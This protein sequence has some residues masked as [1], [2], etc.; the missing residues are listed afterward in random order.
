MTTT[1]AQAVDV[2]TELDENAGVTLPLSSSLSNDDR[3]KMWKL[4]S[5]LLAFGNTEKANELSRALLAS[6]PPMNNMAS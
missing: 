1:E 2:V 4:H 6:L 5:L 3:A